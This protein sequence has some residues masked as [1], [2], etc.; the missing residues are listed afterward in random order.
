MNY[1]EI[2]KGDTFSRAQME[3]LFSVK[4]LEDPKTYQLELMSF[5]A[6]IERATG[7]HVG[8]SGDFVRVFTDLESCARTVRNAISGLR[9]I[10]KSSV[11][12]TR[13]DRSQ[14]TQEQVRASDTRDQVVTGMHIAL[15]AERK[16]QRRLAIVI[17]LPVTDEVAD[18][19]E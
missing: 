17:G 4:Y 16:R 15:Q 13:I 19:A 18:A 3:E 1:S 5:C 11:R 9:K 6:R 14:F 7:F 2:K 8:Q 10:T 12:R